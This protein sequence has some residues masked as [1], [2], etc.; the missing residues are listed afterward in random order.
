MFIDY[1][2]VLEVSP[3]ANA[4]TI[5]RIFRYLAMRY[6][7]DNRETGDEARFSEIVEAHNTL[8]D[9]VKRAQYDIQHRQHSEYHRELG[10]QAGDVK[11]IDLDVVIRDKLLS[12]LYVRRRQDVDHPGIGDWELERLLGCPR[13]LLEFHLWYMK[14]KGWILKSDGQFAITVDGVDRVEAEPVRENA[15]R[16]LARPDPTR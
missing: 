5:E 10:E 8:R 16:L 2:E 1:Y 6:H 9:S 12:L 14:A 4:E 11:R 15:T 7:P 13:E 3:N